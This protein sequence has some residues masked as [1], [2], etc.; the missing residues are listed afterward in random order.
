[1][2]LLLPWPDA[3]CQECC[4]G[5]ACVEV[6]ADSWK[7]VIFNFRG[8]WARGY[9]I[10]ALINQHVTKCSTVGL[11]RVFFGENRSMRFGTCVV[12]LFRCVMLCVFHVLC[13]SCFVYF[14]FWVFLVLCISCFVYSLFCVSLALE[15]LALCIS[16]SV[17]F[18]LCV[19]IVLC[20]SCLVY[21]FTWIYMCSVC[22]INIRNGRCARQEVKRS[23]TLTQFIS[24]VSSVQL[25]VQY[26]Q[27]ED[28]SL[29]TVQKGPH[30]SAKRY[31]HRQTVYNNENKK[32][33]VAWFET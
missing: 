32:F 23:R 22:V 14:L 31:N 21:F 27:S 11:E 8:G 30:V 10:L 29:F 25:K 9:E 6:L 1:M 5:Q 16:C 24:I 2:C 19:F 4:C 26:I 20:I 33:T 3:R 28:Y 17:Y 12:H 15:F 18:L 7:G 13:I